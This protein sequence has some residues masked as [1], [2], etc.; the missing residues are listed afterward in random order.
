M[1][2][3]ASIH[4]CAVV[5]GEA[6]VLIRGPSGSGK[7]A[8][9]MALIEL[10]KMRGQFARLVADDRVRLE[11]RG[12]RLIAAPHPAIAGRIER[13]GQGVG[14]APHLPRA[15]VALVVDLMGADA[16]RLPDPDELWARI[17]GL[18]IPRLALR[19]APIEIAAVTLA[20]L[21]RPP[22]E[23]AAPA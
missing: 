20:R 14:P 5:V 6:C 11:A 4:A 7:S 15:V 18:R 10:A 19:G 9:T 22:G 23:S 16:P 12:G 2:A 13:R 8:A 3:P 17:E 21:R 1:S